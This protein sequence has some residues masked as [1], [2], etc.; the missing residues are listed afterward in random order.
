MDT[1]QVRKGVGPLLRRW[2]QVMT[3]Y[4]VGLCVALG[5]MFIVLGLPLHAQATGHHLDGF[6]DVILAACCGPMLFGGRVCDRWL[7]PSTLG[8]PRASS[9]SEKLSH[10]D[11]AGSGPDGGCWGKGGDAAGGRRFRVC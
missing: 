7:F 5:L 4:G 8:T 1:E 6:L 3:A 11:E 2:P 10:F 9:M